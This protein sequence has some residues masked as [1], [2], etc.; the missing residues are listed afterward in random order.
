MGLTFE[1]A[2]AKRKFDKAEANLKW[3]R[4]RL[5]QNMITLK[6]YRHYQT[7]RDKAYSELFYSF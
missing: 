6:T 5:A 7:R 4:D 2:D 3:A 1:Q